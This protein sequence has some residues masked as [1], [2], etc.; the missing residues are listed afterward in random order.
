MRRFP[1]YSCPGRRIPEHPETEIYNQHRLEALQPFEQD[2]F[3]I[4]S[5]AAAVGLKERMWE[6]TVS[7]WNCL[8]A[9]GTVVTCMWAAQK[10]CGLL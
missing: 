9:M 6:V 3:A 10:L 2:S 8:V 1:E 7:V 5:W 4:F